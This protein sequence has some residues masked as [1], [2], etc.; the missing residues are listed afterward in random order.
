MKKIL[1]L[2]LALVMLF[3]V[4]ALIAGCDDGNK[5]GSSSSKNDKDDEDEDETTAPEGDGETTAPE[6]GETTDPAGDAAE[7][8]AVTDFYF[9]LNDQYIMAI[10]NGDG[11][12]SVDMT[13]DIVKRGNVDASA[14]QTISE[15]LA[16]SGY[17]TLEEIY[18]G[19]GIEYGSLSVSFGEEGF[20]MSECYGAMPEAFT[21][22]FDAMVACFKEVT[23]DLPEYVAVPMEMGEIADSDR[24]ALDAILADLTLP[25]TA[26]SFAING[27]A[28]DE[29]FA[30]SL[31]LSSDSGIISGLSFSPMIMSVA[32][33]LNIVTLESASNANAVAQDFESNIDWLKLICVQPENA[34]IA[35]KDNQVLCL[36]GSGDFYADC[37]VA[38]EAAGW[39]VYSTVANPNM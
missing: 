11:T 16:V 26:D 33:S 13:A 20:F 14:W 10:D 21:A 4:A 36:M 1:A 27:I 2:L 34:Y 8:K 32:Y 3:S 15:G 31:G 7:Y 22:V 6:G 5:K 12:I 17:H 9:S 18:E 23:K 24:A 29:Y 38:I 35:I 39:T 25:T 19:E 37:V 28:K 30:V